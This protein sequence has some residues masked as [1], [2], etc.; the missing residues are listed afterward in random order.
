MT[1]KSSTIEIVAGLLILALGVLYIEIPPLII[2]GALALLGAVKFI[3]VR[4]VLFD[5]G[6][7]PRL[8][9]HVIERFNREH[10]TFLTILGILTYLTYLAI[11]IT[12]LVY[13]KMR[14]A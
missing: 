11:I 9:L 6:S 13:I 5:T 1:L 12:A 7:I 10:N 3:L 14:F 8:D 2:G 4:V